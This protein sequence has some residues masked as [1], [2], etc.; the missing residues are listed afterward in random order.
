[1]ITNDEYEYE[2]YLWC[3]KKIKYY[4]LNNLILLL[5]FL[6]IILIIFKSLT[7]F[8]FKLLVKNTYL[9]KLLILLNLTL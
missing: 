9:Y 4:Y 1:M 7:I 5:L 8:V 2:E 6:F 3:F